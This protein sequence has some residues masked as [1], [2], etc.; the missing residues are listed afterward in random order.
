MIINYT[1]DSS[2][3]A[4]DTVGDPAYN[5]A[6]YAAFTGAVQAAVQYFDTTFINPITVNIAFGWGEV[7][8][9]ALAP[10]TV[11]QNSSFQFGIDYT[12]LYNA[13]QATDTVSAVQRAAVASL[14]ATDPTGGTPFDISTAEAAALGLYVGPASE[15]GGFVGLDNSAQT[16]WSWTQAAVAPNTFDAVGALEHEISEVLGRQASAGAGGVYNTLDLFRYTAADGGAADPAGTAVGVR[17]EPFVLNY[18]ANASSY[19]SYDGATTTIPFETPD[20]VTSGADVADWAPA[21]ANDAFADGGPDGVDAI[22]Q[23]DLQ[24][25]EVLGY[26]VACFLPGTQIATPAGEVA[27][28]QLTI[29]ARV[30]TY[31]GEPSTI[32]W[33]GIGKVLTTRGR[34]NA[35]TPVIVRKDALADNVPNRDLRITKGHSIYIDEILIPVEFLVNHRSIIWDDRA[36]EVTFYHIELAVHDVLVANGAPAESYRDDGNRWMFRNVNTGWDQPPKSPCA[37]VLT[38]GPVVDEVWQRLLRRSGP[39]PGLPLTDDADLH[40]MVGQTRISGRHRSNG[41]HVFRLLRS[42]GSTGSTSI[43]ILS[44]AGAPDELGLA[45]DPRVLGVAI[46]RIVLWQGQQAT[47]IEAEDERLRTGFHAYEADGGLRWTDGNAELS[48]DMFK[49]LDGAITI[50]IYVAGTARYPLLQDER[51]SAA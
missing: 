15:I 49:E 25:M 11:G 34:R 20:N 13:L 18:D 27:V 3:T 46:Q 1:Y 21:V 22:S 35:A 10:G 14:P 8:G 5:P 24:T 48:P 45:R 44:R 12:T 17:D 2:V 16:A 30:L 26:E 50:D 29:G 33:I 4:L 40:L 6:L 7:D 43:R 41:V 37:P 38:G 23:T 28:E 31:R 39:R 32:T 47:V 9:F 51:S 42:P 19:F 36:R